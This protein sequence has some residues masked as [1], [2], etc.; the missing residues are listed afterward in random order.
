[1]SSDLEM[2]SEFSGD[3]SPPHSGT[4][5]RDESD[6]DM[7][8]QEI[9]D[10]LNGPDDHE[11]GLINVHHSDSVDSFGGHRQQQSVSTNVVLYQ[12]C[13]MAVL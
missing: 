3:D 8:E 4:Y 5:P 12:S 2:D 13:S 10:V 11:Q 7:L 6:L 9:D 1:M